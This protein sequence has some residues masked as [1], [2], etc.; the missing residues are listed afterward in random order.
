M[1]TGVRAQLERRILDN[2]DRRVF[3][4]TIAAGVLAAAGA[5]AAG[6]TL[7]NGFPTRATQVRPSTT[8][9]AW[10]PVPRPTPETI[11][12]PAHLR[13]FFFPPR[14]NTVPIPHGTIT[15]LPGAGNLVALTVDDGIS[16]EVVALY[17]EFARTSGMRITFFLNGSRPSWTDNA[18]A[19][20]PLVES[21]QAQL[22]NHTWSHPSLLKLTDAGVVREL[23][24]ND[25]FIR[26]VYGVEAKPY[27]RPP[28]GF[29]DKHV[30]AI[31]ASIG[32]STPVLWYGSLS[33]SGLITPAQL[34]GFADQW[35]LAQHIVIGHANFPPV[36]QCFDYLTDLIRTR[37]LQPVTLNDVFTR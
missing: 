8:P 28:F 31:A 22:A 32:Y 29:H 37:K 36:T 5:V 20:R 24:R 25:V 12:A 21:G 19:L 26:T 17:A 13:P 6:A 18:L 23:T 11:V 34:K 27:F 4:G 7:E 33:D 16:S 1:V 14:L 9:S 15:G 10:P 2:V 30:D 3:F 35:I